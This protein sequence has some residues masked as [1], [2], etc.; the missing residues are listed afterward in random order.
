MNPRLDTLD[1]KILK[2][3]LRPNGGKPVCSKALATKLGVPATTVQRRRKRL[4]QAGILKTSYGA[5]PKCFGWHNVDYL[6]STSCG[7]TMEIAKKLS[8]M[9]QVV[10][11]T[12][13]I[14]QPTIDLRVET[15][16]RDNQEILNTLETIKGIKGVTDAVWT[17]AMECVVDKAP[18]PVYLVDDM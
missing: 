9:K 14:G 6:V 7:R 10:S 1:K 2:L 3:I 4:E 15:V 8:G 11:I 18:I 5:D 16:L 12:R 17:E 13:T